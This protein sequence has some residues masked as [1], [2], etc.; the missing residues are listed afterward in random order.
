MLTTKY[1]WFQISEAKITILGLF[2]GNIVII[3]IYFGFRRL[4][5]FMFYLHFG[6]LQSMFH[7]SRNQDVDYYQKNVWKSPLEEGQIGTSFEEGISATGQTARTAWSTLMKINY[8]DKSE[9]SATT[10]WLH[11]RNKCI[12]HL[13]VNYINW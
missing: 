5:I 2:P 7:L 1:G 6:F 12:V 9:N 10:S 3:S 4:S 13:L 11:Y 8:A